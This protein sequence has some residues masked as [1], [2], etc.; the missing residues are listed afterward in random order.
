MPALEPASEIA[1]LEPYPGLGLE[2]IA[3]TAQGPDARYE[4]RGPCSW[5]SSP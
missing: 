4:L 1:W 5:P 3:D 2:G